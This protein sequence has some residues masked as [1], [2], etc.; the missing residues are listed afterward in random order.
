MM[1]FACLFAV[2]ACWLW[3]AATRPPA[4]RPGA[5]TIALT[6]AVVLGVGLVRL[7][8]RWLVVGGVLGVAAWSIHRLWVRVRRRRRT[9]ETAEA[10]LAACELLAAE[11]AAGRSPPSA[12]SRAAEDWPP[13]RPVAET[14]TFGGDVPAALRQLSSR[15]G[16]GGLRLVGAAWSVTQH[17]GRGLAEA[18]GHVAD[19]VRADQ[20]TARVV[21]GELASARA[22]ARLV[23]L[24]PAAALLMAA[25]G[26][27]DPVG[28]LV[29]GP[30]GIACLGTGLALG[31][32]GVWWIESI[33]DAVA[34]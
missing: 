26:G 2:L 1:V 19:A 13:L 3:T 14:A 25:G 5:A 17:S 20:R 34:P 6:C 28:F 9:S 4:R 10:V 33:A 8:P 11:L 15:P 22:T 7:G 21:T 29:G 32:A 12:L 16:A 24:L 27:G 23:A 31:L 30:A 18:L